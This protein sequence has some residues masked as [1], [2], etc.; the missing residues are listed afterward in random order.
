MAGAEAWAAGPAVLLPDSLLV[1]IFLF[2][3]PRDL[4]SAGASCRQWHAVAQDQAL[5]KELFYRHFRLPRDLPRHPGATSWSG[6]FRRLFE[7]VP[8]LETEA[9][10]Q[11]ADHV[12]HL[13]FSRSGD[14]FASCSKDCTAKI[15]STGPEEISLQHSA[16]MKEYNWSYTQFSQF[17]P[18]DSLLLVSGVFLGPRS[19]SSGEIAV[20]S[21]EDFSL[22]SR[23]RNKPPDL[24]GCW[25]NE[26][27]LLSGNLHRIGYLT[28]CSVLWLS[29]AFQDIESENTNV[30]K[31]LFKIQNLNAS[32][33]RTV[34]L[35]D[36]SRHDSP[37]LLLDGGEPRG[38]D[39]S[40]HSREGGRDGRGAE[41]AEGAAE[42]GL[43]GFLGLCPDRTELEA[44]ARVA[45]IMARRRTKPP[46]GDL[47]CDRGGRAA[48]K[49]LVFTTGCL[50]YVPHQIGRKEAPSA[51]PDPSQEIASQPR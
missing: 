11:H 12:L 42:G 17:S 6:E 48:H 1:E 31:R 30:V 26:T 23:V 51:P 9:L 21:L 5:W 18:D 39:L 32:A 14:L 10:K 27:N 41:V 36:C 15:W 33:V 8:C 44:E 19:S 40:G 35:V 24:L 13:A 22:V 46:E 28:S 25:L 43:S 2:L 34:M 50:T 37:D 4:L 38:V 29:N 16:S 47:L 20:F 7:G 3:G 45:R 49:Y